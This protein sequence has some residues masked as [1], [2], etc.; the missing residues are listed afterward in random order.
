M[1]NLLLLLNSFKV[2]SRD[3][4]ELLQS[5]VICKHWS[6]K[7][8][9]L[10]M[11]QVCREV[12][13]LE[14][15]MVHIYGIAEAYCRVVTTW[16]LEEG[17]IFISP[18]SFFEQIPSLENIQAVEPCT[19]WSFRHAQLAAV[20]ERYPEFKDLQDL[21]KN[22]YYGMSEN[23]RLMMMG[24]SPQERCNYLYETRPA[25][26]LRAPHHILSSYLEIH[27]SDIAR[28]INQ[29]LRGKKEIKGK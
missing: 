29:T 22:K 20:C 23:W 27:K 4:E 6:Q 14:K 1:K 16:V 11:G 26:I 8:I 28:L 7:D 25:L 3:V 24:L 21:I 5:M 15:G 17:H 13:F 18:V 19:T 12:Y 10:A 2:L 9:I